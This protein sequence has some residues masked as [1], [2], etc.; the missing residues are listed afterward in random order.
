LLCGA[1]CDQRTLSTGKQWRRRRVGG[2]DAREASEKRH[3]RCNETTKGSITRKRC[4]DTQSHTQSTDFPSPNLE[5][6]PISKIVKSEWN[7]TDSWDDS[8]TKIWM[9][10]GSTSGVQTNLLSFFRLLAFFQVI[11]T[12]ENSR[13]LCEACLCFGTCYENNVCR[14]LPLRRKTKCKHWPI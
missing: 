6:N 3:G 10:L 8:K 13:R 4:R 5:S 11:F 2:G 14:C 7:H 1:Y 9:N 12:R